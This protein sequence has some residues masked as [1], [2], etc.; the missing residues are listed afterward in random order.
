MIIGGGAS[1]VILAAQLLQRSV[2]ARAII[3]ERSEEI[4]KGIAYSTE[5]PNHLLNVRAHNM[6][7]FP[8]Q[9]E[10]FLNWLQHGPKIS[11]SKGWQPQSFAPRKLFRAY[12]QD[13]LVPYCEGDNPRLSIVKD[14]VYDVTVNDG[15]PVVT[16]KAGEYFSA[17]AIILATGNET[18]IAKSGQEVTEYWSSHGYFDVPKDAPVAIFGTGL[19]MV[20][21][22]LSL[23]DRG[24]KGTIHALSR[25]GLVPARHVDVKA[26]AL[27]EATLF[28]NQELAAQTYQFRGLIRAAKAEGYDWRAVMDALRPHSQKI[29]KDLS[30]EQRRRFLRHLRPWWDVHRHRMAPSVADRIDAARASGQLRILAGRLCSVRNETAAGGEGMVV[31]Y[32]ERHTRRAVELPVGAIIDCRGGNPKFSRTRNPVLQSL[33]E[34][35]LAR[36]DA[37]DLGLDVTADLQSIDAH[38]EASRCIFALGP[39]TKGVFWEVTAIPDI[40][41]QAEKL[42]RYLLAV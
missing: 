38:G 1:G 18:A 37:L 15:K 30:H 6:S 36:P 16:T 25:R 41:V 24:H 19:S 2:S 4:G 40:R 28:T 13:I 27:D 35:A 42:S 39:V 10:H 11:A 12:L 29:W 33:M 9:P 7:A 14:A 20:D 26:Y 34:N 22:V 8:D 17:D 21:S 5:N 32:C 31:C 23:L 3:F